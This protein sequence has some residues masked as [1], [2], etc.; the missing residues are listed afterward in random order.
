MNLA[1][2]MQEIAAAVDEI[3]GLRVTPHPIETVS[4][5]A[6]G[7][8]Y[9]ERIVYDLT[10]GRGMTKFQNLPVVVVLGVVTERATRD[11]MGEYTAVTGDRSLYARFNGREWTSCDMVIVTGCEFD[12]VIYGDS[13]YLQATFFC[14]ITS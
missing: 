14:D 6:A 7:V 11:R 2:V 1:E 9:P 12:S 4:P 8:T 5:P 13:A 10:Y 3:T